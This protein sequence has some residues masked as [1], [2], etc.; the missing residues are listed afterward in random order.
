M[1]PSISRRRHPTREAHGAGLGKP[2]EIEDPAWLGAQARHENRRAEPWAV[3]DAPAPFIVTQI[4]AIVCLEIEIARI[5]GKKAS[6]NRQ[7]ADRTGVAA[8]LEQ[9]GDDASLAM[10]RLVRERAQP[11]TGSSADKPS[12]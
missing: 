6:Q 3:E 9:Q 8:G 11:S 4:K 2:R 5:E 12:R 1:L 10:A 7:P